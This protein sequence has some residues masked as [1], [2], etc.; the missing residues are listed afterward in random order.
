M[1]PWRL[2]KPFA[3]HR[4]EY[5]RYSSKPLSCS[6]GCQRWLLYLVGF[7]IASPLQARPTL[8]YAQS[9]RFGRRRSAGRAKPT[10][11]EVNFFAKRTPSPVAADLRLDAG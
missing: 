9:V 6:N 10:D 4:G 7:D 11:P 2:A 3:S 8:S 5:D 1:F